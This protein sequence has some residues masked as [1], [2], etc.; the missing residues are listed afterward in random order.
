MAGEGGAGLPGRRHRGKPRT[1]RPRGVGGLGGGGG[2]SNPAGTLFLLA[3]ARALHAQAEA[4]HTQMSSVATG[5]RMAVIHAKM[6]VEVTTV[7][8]DLGRVEQA[9]VQL[10]KRCPPSPAASRRRRWTPTLGAGSRASRAPP[11]GI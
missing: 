5:L 9:H 8:P 6:E 10:L 11:G 4:T 2:A 3:G 7:T 1:R